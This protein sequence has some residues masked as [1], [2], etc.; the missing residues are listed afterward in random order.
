MNFNTSISGNK[1][2]VSL[3]DL[4][5]TIPLNTIVCI[6]DS[7]TYGKDWANSGGLAQT[8][9]VRLAQKYPGTAFVNLGKNSDTSA[10]VNARKADADPYNPFRVIVWI[11][12]NDVSGGASEE[13]I[14]T[15]LQSI[16]DYYKSKNY[17]V[18][19]MTIPPCDSDD[20]TKNIIRANVNLWI[21]NVAP[22]V[23]WV[24]DAAT[25]LREPNT[26]LRRYIYA[27]PNSENH[28]NDAGFAAVVGSFP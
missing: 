20:S 6:G 21:G 7:L 9:N 15:N 24:I 23:S 14:K 12:T 26:W 28:F 10:G 13:T 11:G 8:L 19:A 17:D 18:W 22:N 27:D 25:I 1:L 3:Y 5:V 4:A 16:Y 2:S